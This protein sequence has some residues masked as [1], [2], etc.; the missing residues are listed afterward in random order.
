MYTD[1][2]LQRRVEHTAGAVGEQRFSVL[3]DVKV[4]KDQPFPR[5]VT[6]VSVW[7]KHKTEARKIASEYAIRILGQNFGRIIDVTK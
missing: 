3:Y 6:E 4:K 5:E 2:D 1:N 7:A